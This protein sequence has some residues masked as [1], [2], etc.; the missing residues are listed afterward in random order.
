[1]NGA[2]RRLLELREIESD[3]DFLHAVPG[4]P[5]RE[6]RAAI[7]TLFREREPIN[8]GEVELE[9]N[10]RANRY[11]SLSLALMQIEA[12]LPD[13]AT[14]C[15]TDVTQM[16]QVR[17]QLETVQAQQAQLMNELGTANKHLSN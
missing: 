3:Q 13:L 5:Y 6:T 12:G 10:T 2:A 8:L 11:V 14:I 17:R 4:I 7:D 1:A 16:V 15:I 9:S